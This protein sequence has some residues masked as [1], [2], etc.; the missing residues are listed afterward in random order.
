MPPILTLCNQSR[1]GRDNILV[2]I[3]SVTQCP[4]ITN[5]F[6]IVN[7]NL[8][9]AKFASAVCFSST[10]LHKMYFVIREIVTVEP[11]LFGFSYLSIIG[12]GRV[13]SKPRCNHNPPTIIFQHPQDSG[14][15]DHIIKGFCFDVRHGVFSVNGFQPSFNTIQVC[16]CSIHIEYKCFH[17][18]FLPFF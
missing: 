12:R 6:V 17:F 4:T 9:T 13:I 2:C 14:Q 10:I 7:Q 3:N 15:D 1:Q 16:D 11:I 18:L 8:E 5:F